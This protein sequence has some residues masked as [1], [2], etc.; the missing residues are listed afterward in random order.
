M[1]VFRRVQ[2]KLSDQDENVFYVQLLPPFE[3]IRTLTELQKVLAPAASGAVKSIQSVNM[4]A[5]LGK[6]IS[7]GLAEALLTVSERLT[8]EES[9]KITRKLLNPEYVAVQRPHD[10]S[11]VRLTE[12]VVGDIFTGRPIDLIILMVKIVQVN[13]LDFS[14]LSGI[15]SGILADIEVLKGIFRE[16]AEKI[17]VKNSLSGGQSKKGSRRLPKSKTVK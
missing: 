9:D 13:Y 7:G 4:D 10:S 3:A 15:P 16:N 6:A 12:Q 2:V 5:S 14:R 1:D 11:P 8:E 17:S